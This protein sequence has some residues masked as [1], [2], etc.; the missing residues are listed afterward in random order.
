MAMHDRCPCCG[1]GSAVESVGGEPS[2]QTTHAEWCWEWGPKHYKCAVREIKALRAEVAE[3]KRVAASQAELH[4]EAEERAERLAE[5]L[6][7]LEERE[8]SDDA[9]LQQALEALERGAWDT[10]RGRN[11]AFA[12][13]ERL[14]LEQED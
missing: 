3:W 7:K 14:G 10:L 2:A 9:L 4:G 11:A 1:R 6:R 5:A 8:Q 13:R 12:I